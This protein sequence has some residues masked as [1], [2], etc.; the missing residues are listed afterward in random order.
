MIN[1]VLTL[2]VRCLRHAATKLENMVY[3]R[4]IYALVLDENA[5]DTVEFLSNLCNV[6][7]E[8]FD[9][10]RSVEY[11]S[12]I[13]PDLPDG[14]YFEIFEAIKEYDKRQSFVGSYMV[15]EAMSK[16]KL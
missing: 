8:A 6:D 2:L 7:N 11:L 14:S 3:R 5:V 4:Q 13:A 1:T 15:K 9:A 16:V 12:W 10:N